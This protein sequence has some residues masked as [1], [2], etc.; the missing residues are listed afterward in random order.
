MGAVLNLYWH[1]SINFGDMLSPYLLKK[2]KGVEINYVEPND[3]AHKYVLTGSILSA[4]LVNATVFGAGFI[5]NDDTFIGE[6]VKI[7]GVRGGYTLEKLK[8][9]TEVP[10]GAIVG[11]PSYCLPF[12]YNPKPAKKY[13][14][15]IMPHISDMEDCFISKALEKSI[16]LIALLKV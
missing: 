2:F 16:C 13:K 3:P 4:R 5:S 15:G 12:F 1:R 14:L 11:D 8:T 6:N 7:K 9:F 10:E